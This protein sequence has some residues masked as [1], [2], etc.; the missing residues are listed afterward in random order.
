MLLHHSVWKR[1]SDTV[2]SAWNELSAEFHLIWMHLYEY[3]SSS[4]TLSHLFRAKYDF[5]AL[6]TNEKT[7]IVS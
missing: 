6:Y 7:V 2:L 3:Y 5:I 1:S 4:S